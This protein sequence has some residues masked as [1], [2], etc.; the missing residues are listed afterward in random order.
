MKISNRLT[1]AGVLLCIASAGARA[2]DGEGKLFDNRA[3]HWRG[4]RGDVASGAVWF[5]LRRIDRR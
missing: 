4:L 3:C 1:T 2:E 5:R